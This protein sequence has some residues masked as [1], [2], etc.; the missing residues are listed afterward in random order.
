MKKQRGREE[1]TWSKKS[2]DEWEFKER[3]EQKERNKRKDGKKI[4]FMRKNKKG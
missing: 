1:K 2:D 3:E 4:V